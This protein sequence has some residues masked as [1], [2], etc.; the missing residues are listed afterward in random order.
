MLVGC[1][2]SSLESRSS[3]VTVAAGERFFVRWK[4]IAE[5]KVVADDGEQ[6]TRWMASFKEWL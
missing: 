3:L 6:Q 1:R 4:A 2:A 5:R